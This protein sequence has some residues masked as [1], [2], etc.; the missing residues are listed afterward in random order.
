[1]AC[2]ITS[3]MLGSHTSRASHLSPRGSISETSSGVL[4]G[5]RDVAMTLCPARKAIRARLN[6]KPEDEPVMSHTGDIIA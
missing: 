1:M 5:V 4:D 6:P 2:S 3:A